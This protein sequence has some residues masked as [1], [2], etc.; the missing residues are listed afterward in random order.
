[1]IGPYVKNT[2]VFVCPSAQNIGCSIY[3]LAPNGYNQPLSY[4]KTPAEFGLLAEAASWP[5]AP[6]GDYYDP[7]SWGNPT[8]GAHWQVSWPGQAQYDGTGCGNCTRRPYV[9]HNGGLNIG[10]ADGHVKWMKGTMAVKTPGLW[11]P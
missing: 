2:Q 3:G 6:P 7:E 5:K 11:T 4:F 8:G 10:F 9:V 1:M